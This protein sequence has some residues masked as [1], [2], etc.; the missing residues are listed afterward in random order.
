M[1]AFLSKCRMRATAAIFHWL[2]TILQWSLKDVSLFYDFHLLQHYQGILMPWYV[3]PHSM[4]WAKLPR[5]YII[6]SLISS[7]KIR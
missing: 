2:L 3:Y 5:L 7:N 4:A 6:F 1:D